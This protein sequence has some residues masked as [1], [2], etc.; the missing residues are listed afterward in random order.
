MGGMVNQSVF[1]S[2]LQSVM[3]VRDVNF[4]RA[5]HQ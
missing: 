5:I 4:V 2:H 1:G 3:G